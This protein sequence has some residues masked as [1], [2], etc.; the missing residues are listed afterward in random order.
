MNRSWQAMILAAGFGKRLYPLTKWMPKPLVPITQKPLLHHVSKNLFRS[1]INSIALNTHHLPDQIQSFVG[2]SPDKDRFILFHEPVILNT[3]GALDHA[4]SY[5]REKPYFLVHNSDIISNTDLLKLINEHEKSGAIVT[6]ALQDKGNN[7]VIL[8]ENN[9]VQDIRG[10]L[11]VSHTDHSRRVTYSG[12]AAFSSEFLEYLPKG[13]SDL[14]DTLVKLMQIKPGSVRGLFDKDSYWSDLGTFEEFFRTQREVID[15]QQLVLDFPAQALVE[16]GSSRRYYRLGE[17]SNSLVLMLCEFG[18]PDF[19]RFIETSKFLNS[20]QLGNP[21]MWAWSDTQFAALLE[22]LGDDTIYRLVQNN[23]DPNFIRG[24]YTKVV[25]FLVEF[26]LSAFRAKGRCQVAC[27]RTMDY[28]QL[29]WETRYFCK[30]FL[31]KRLGFPNET[32]ASLDPEFHFLAKLV[33]THPM[34]LIHRDFQSQNLLLKEGEIH[35]VDYQGMRKGS[36][37]Y[38]FMSLINDPYV[39]LSEELKVILKQEFIQLLENEEE[40]ACSGAEWERRML[41]AGLQRNM[42]ALGAYAFLSGEKGKSQFEKF[43]RP[44]CQILLEGIGDWNR[45]FRHIMDLSKLEDTV[46]VSLEKCIY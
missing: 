30:E 40:L 24:I 11:G 5:L 27:D 6:L 39:H 2:Q 28:D 21:A 12:I 4:S 16:Q 20:L 34:T 19:T 41:T 44:G 23:N 8:D 3:G 35:V 36:I 22:D 15:H 38:D 43:M 17:G 46:R 14:I 25:H 42:Q 31:I 29:R 32:L 26:H 33:S 9:I 1:G 7:N 45:N 18:D 13:P 10:L 37:A